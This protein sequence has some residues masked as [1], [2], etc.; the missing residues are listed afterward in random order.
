LKI[1]ADG[2][3]EIVVTVTTEERVVS[4][5]AVQC[6]VA[7]FAIEGVAAVAPVEGIRAVPALERVVANTAAERVI[8]IVAA[9]RVIAGIAGENVCIAVAGKRVIENRAGKVFDIDDGVGALTAPGFAA[10]SAGRSNSACDGAPGLGLGVKTSVSLPAPSIVSSPVP[11]SNVSLPS[12]PNHT[13]LPL[14]LSPRPAARAEK[15]VAGSAITRVVAV[16]VLEDVIAVSTDQHIITEASADEV[17]ASAAVNS[18][19]AVYAD[20]PVVTITTVYYVV[21]AKTVD[22]VIAAQTHDGVAVIG[23]KRLARNGIRRVDQIVAGCTHDNRHRTL[24]WKS[25]GDTM[26]TGPSDRRSSSVKNPGKIPS[27]WA[28]LSEKACFLPGGERPM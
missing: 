9:K 12:S 2:A 3:D 16:E 27:N 19:V 13:S 28:I 6:I 18:V 26:R 10:L 14:P 4:A 25:F 15:V 21:A 24:L 23:G 5:T 1:V 20:D 17:V 22:V 11:V 7:I 8:A